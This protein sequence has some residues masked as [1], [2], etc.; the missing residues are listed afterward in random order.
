M[1]EGGVKEKKGWKKIV[2]VV[3]DSG[4]STDGWM[5]AWRSDAMLLP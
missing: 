2:F 4:N 3:L 5:D 1:G